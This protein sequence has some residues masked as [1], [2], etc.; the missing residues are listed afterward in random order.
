MNRHRLCG[1][2]L[3]NVNTSTP[4][5]DYVPLLMIFSS[6]LPQTNEL[7]A[8]TLYLLTGIPLIIVLFYVYFK[9]NTIEFFRNN[10]IDRMGIIVTIIVIGLIMLSAFYSQLVVVTNMLSMLLLGFQSATMLMRN[11]CLK[12]KTDGPEIHKRAVAER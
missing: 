9:F 2:F 1:L 3:L 7:V 8:K 12:R 6:F 4:S 5:W 10:A 11:K